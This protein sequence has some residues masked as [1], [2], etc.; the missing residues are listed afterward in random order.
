[1]LSTTG[2]VEVPGGKVPVPR[3]IRP[4]GGGMLYRVI[5][6]VD[7]GHAPYDVTE[8][9]PDRLALARI[10]ESVGLFCYGGCAAV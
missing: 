4:S 3:L 1:M 2:D 8:R 6:T 7:S 5:R 9:C 10:V